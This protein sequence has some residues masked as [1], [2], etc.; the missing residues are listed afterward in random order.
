MYDDP[1]KGREE[2]IKIWNGI[3]LSYSDSLQIPDPVPP[4]IDAPY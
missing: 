1:K 4:E 2:A 3:P